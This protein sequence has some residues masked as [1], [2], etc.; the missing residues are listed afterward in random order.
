MTRLQVQKFIFSNKNIT[1]LICASIIVVL[2]FLGIVKQ[3]WFFISFVA[4]FFGYLVCPKEKELVFYHVKGENISDYIGFLDKFLRNSLDNPKLSTEAKEILQHITKNATELLLFL[5]EKESYD[6]LSEDMTNLKS[7]FDNYIPK[8]VNQF[9]RLPSEYSHNVK[10]STGRTAQAMFIEQLYLLE[11]KIE[12]ISFGIYEDDIT[13]LK[14][15]GRFLKEKF[16]T[17]DLF[18][19]QQQVNK[20]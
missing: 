3:G 16:E 2:A 9:T 6:F 15:N 17:N 7:I 5:Q 18:S 19:L 13:S 8:L 20:K 10:T 12:E 1:G 11:R 14:I 4:Y